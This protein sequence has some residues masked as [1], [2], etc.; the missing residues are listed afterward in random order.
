MVQVPMEDKPSL[1]PIPVVRRLTKYLA[2]LQESDKEWVSSQELGQALSLTDSTVRQDLCH[3]DFSGRANRGYEVEGL[4]KILTSA[5]GLDT[6]RN[7]VIV[8]AGNLGRALA[9]HEDFPRRGFRICGIFD[10]DP[11]LF[12]RKLGRLVVQG[13]DALPKVVR[14]EGV[15]IGIMA[16]PASAARVVAMELM[17]AGVRGLLNMACA[18]VTIPEDVAIVD[19][20]IVESLQELACV[21]GMARDRN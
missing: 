21:I 10:A 9:L 15:D 5:L 17:A 4:E 13:M 11:K 3:L 20:R 14:N 6:C 1:I 16:V 2:H 12:G 7:A 18:H 8:G 19:A